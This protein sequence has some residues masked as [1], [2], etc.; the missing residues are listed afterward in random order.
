V[1]SLEQLAREIARLSP[2]EL[3]L[4]ARAIAWSTEDKAPLFEQY[5]HNEN[6]T[7]TLLRERVNETVPASY[8]SYKAK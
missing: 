3:K 1:K 4:L 2:D 5:L 8:A 7:V 6:C